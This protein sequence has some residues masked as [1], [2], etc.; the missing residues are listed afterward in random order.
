MI[1]GLGSI[2][3]RHLRNLLALGERDILL[4][5]TGRSV[6]PEDE[7]AGFPVETDLAAALEHRP[8]AVIVANPTALHL[9]VAIPAAE[10]GCHLLIE[11]P[12]SH[13]LEGVERLRE[14][15]RRGG[16]QVLVGYQ[17]RFH[18]GLQ[19]IKQ[20]LSPP[21]SPLTPYLN[22][23]SQS[24]DLWLTAASQSSD[25][26]QRLTSDP[27]PLTSPIGRPLS[28]RAHWGEYLP[29][30]HPWEDYR[31][32][33]SARADLGGGALLTLSHPLDYLR[34]FFGEVEALWAFAGRL[35]DLALDVEDTA[36]IGLRFADGVLGSVHL[37]YN[38]RPS[39]HW[40]EIIGT[41]GTIR[42]DNA[43]GAVHLAQF[44]VGA[45]NVSSLQIPVP[46]GFVRNDLF[47]REMR[48]FLALGGG[49]EAPACTLEDGIQDL[50]VALAA[51]R[52]SEAGEIAL[53]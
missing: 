18:P 46:A 48:H 38:Q 53:L 21:S 8:E 25:A 35:G 49:E 22:S 33:Y 2:G 43:D 13:S 10:R 32:G 7:L 52:S 11:K 20:L 37:D 9:E 36:E 30:W 14:A 27:S 6:L 47:L 16:G 29:G 42:W 17:F 50:R 12:L 39:A 24:S 26:S 51:R 15:V 34:W 41:Q 23:A 1:A 40:L 28:A 5:R 44:P 45:E 4:Y 31:Q 3:R 19:K